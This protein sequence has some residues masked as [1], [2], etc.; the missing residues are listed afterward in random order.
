VLIL[1]A[2]ATDNDQVAYVE[3]QYFDHV[4][5]PHGWIYIGSDVT[6]PYQVPFDTSV[7]QA[8][9]PADP[10]QTAVIGVDRAGN[11][12][13]PGDPLRVIYVIRRHAVYMPLLRK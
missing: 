8:T 10:Y 3:F 13:N 9:S 11:R 1:E 7:L 2:S 5:E 6:Y 12:S 4:N